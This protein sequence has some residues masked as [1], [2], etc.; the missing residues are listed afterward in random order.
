MAESKDIRTSKIPMVMSPFA[1]GDD[2]KEMSLSFLE[3][4]VDREFTIPVENGGKPFTRSHLNA[5]GYFATLG[6]YLDRLGYPYGIDKDIALDIGGYP[7]GAI[8]I[9]ED[10]D[11]VREYV[12]LVENNTHALPQE[13]DD[14]T[15]EGNEYWGVTIPPVV[16]FY[17]DFSTSYDKKTF[18]I[19]GTGTYGYE[20]YTIDEDGWYQF[21]GIYS[22]GWWE[23]TPGFGT[24]LF[25]AYCNVAI[26]GG[27][28]KNSIGRLDG[29]M[30]IHTDAIQGN[31]YGYSFVSFTMPLRKGVIVQIQH[32]LTEKLVLRVN[33]KRWGNTTL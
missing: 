22:D 29:K 18:N 14:G 25:K 20:S 9:T 33:I 5:I 31:T 30:T 15:Y 12:S 16:D 10:N 21:T 28:A 13:T 26:A 7:K 6:G 11:Y 24:E 1:S 3:N 4:G 8:L 27:D 17:P 23:K 32:N 2:Q 19:T